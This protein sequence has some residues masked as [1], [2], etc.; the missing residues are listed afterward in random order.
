MYF[1]AALPAPG[2][3]K[4]AGFHA[5]LVKCQLR[6]GAQRRCLTSPTHRACARRGKNSSGGSGSSLALGGNVVMILRSGFM[7]PDLAVKLVGQFIHGGIKIGVGTLGEYIAA[8]DMHIALG[9]LASF[10]FF[11]VVNGQKDFHIHD[12]I[13][14]PGDPVEFGGHVTAQGGGD[15]EMVAADCQIHKKTPHSENV[16]VLGTG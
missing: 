14:M 10:L 7:A 6:H 2:K 5:A 11:H 8:L 4:A 13:E 15:F 9:F 12:L 3:Q 1:T 16:P